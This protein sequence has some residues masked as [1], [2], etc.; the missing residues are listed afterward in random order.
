MKTLALT[1]LLE[2]RLEFLREKYRDKVEEQLMN[3]LMAA[4]PTSRNDAPGGYADWVIRH[5]LK[6]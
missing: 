1:L 3:Q 4:D 5:Y 2:G 6:A